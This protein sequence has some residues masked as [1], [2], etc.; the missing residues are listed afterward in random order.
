MLMRRASE[1]TAFVRMASECTMLVERA[2]ECSTCARRASECTMR[3]VNECPIIIQRAS[4][5]TMFLQRASECTTLMRT[6][7]I[8][9]FVCMVLLILHFYRI[10]IRLWCC[11]T[12]I[13]L[14]FFYNR[15]SFF[16]SFLVEVSQNQF[17]LLT[18]H[19]VQYWRWNG[20]SDIRFSSL[21]LNASLPPMTKNQQVIITSLYFWYFLKYKNDRSVSHLRKHCLSIHQNL[22]TPLF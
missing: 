14:F 17:F 22:L 1:W 19:F 15:K 21:F 4:E 6:G 20:F 11:H 13:L 16:F 3:R 12:I 8:T 2:S 18:S 10:F 5:S 9:M 7:E